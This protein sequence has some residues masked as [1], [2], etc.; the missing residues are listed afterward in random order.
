MSLPTGVRDIATFMPVLLQS[1]KFRTQETGSI[2][3]PHSP[4][5][6]KGVQGSAIRWSQGCVNAAGKARQ[7]WYL[8][9]SSNKIRQSCGP[10]FSRA[11]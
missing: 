2:V 8:S 4:F 3:I 1:Q 7:K 9:K 6:T 5:P 11:L 10:P